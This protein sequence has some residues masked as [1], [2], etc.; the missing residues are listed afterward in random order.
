MLFVEFI[1]DMCSNFLLKCFQAQCIGI[2][3]ARPNYTP[4][5]YMYT[6]GCYLNSG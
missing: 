4:S 6:S 5:T 3:L 2:H 1:F